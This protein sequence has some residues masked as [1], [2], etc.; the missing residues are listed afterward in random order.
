MV[1]GLVKKSVQDLVDKIDTFIIKDNIN[2]RC[3]EMKENSGNKRNG[4]IRILHIAQA[5]GGVERYLYMLFKH[6]NCEEYD[7]ILLCS[8]DY[9]K[10]K[11]ET[12]TK[13]CVQI[14]MRREIGI[15]DLNAIFRVRK[16]IKKYKP[17]IVYAHSSKAGAIVRIANICIKNTCIYNPHGWAFNMECSSLKKGLYKTI[18]KALSFLCEKIICISDAEKESA[19]KNDICKQEKLCVIYNGIEISE[20]QDVCTLSR[21]QLGIPEEAFVVGMVGRLSKQKAPDIFIRAAELIKKE[22]PNAFFV[23]V[24]SGDLENDIKEY[25]KKHAL[26]DSLLITGWVDEPNVYINCFDVATLLSRWE[27][28]GLVLAEYMLAEKPIVA[29]NIDAIPNLITDQ[30]NGLLVKINDYHDVAQN[31]ISL[32]DSESLKFELVQNAFI[33]VRER[34]DITRVVKDNEILF[35]KLVG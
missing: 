21:T 33:V 4:K 24:G 2:L 11:F 15:H 34:F 6:M 10:S 17:D 35:Q 9:N 26:E 31:V 14:E 25:A 28:F 5:A 22:I 20:K 13:D 23:M 16:V 27:G 8:Q 1:E 32:Y 3:E 7:N 18:E 29:T 19:I 12:V 30:Y